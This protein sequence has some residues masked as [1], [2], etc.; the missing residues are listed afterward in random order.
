MVGIVT[1]GS[2]IPI[3]RIRVEEIA[4]VWGDDGERVKKSLGVF[5]K[6]VPGVDEDAATISVEAVRNA[7]R[8]KWIP[9]EEIGAVLVGS[10]SHPYVVKPTA[11]I[12]AEAI[13]ATPKVMAADHE[14]ACKAGT[15]AMQNI[16]GLVKSG[17]IKYGVAIGADTSQG[18]PG[19]PLEYTAS[20]GG[21]A[22]I[23][24]EEEV[25][26]EI[27]HTLSFTTDTPDFWRR[28]KQDYP[29]HGGRF[30]GEPAYFRH[31]LGAAKLMMEEMN[32][33]PED[34]TYAVFHQPNTK[35]PKRVAKKLGFNEEQIKPGLV[36]PWIGN[37][38]SGCMITGLSAIL[39]IAKPGDRILAV[40]FGSGAGSDAFDITVTENIEKINRRA[41]PT[42]R[43]MIERAVY[44]DYAL[45]AKFRKKI[46]LPPGV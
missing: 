37:T 6:S 14:F 35:F 2:Y 18:A 7:L 23:I 38:Y 17:M 8:R 44:I 16:I 45:Y 24:G 9:P 28:E 32:T 13:G 29:Q 5:S 11:T 39:D 22:F 21:T 12:V 19:D 3:Y 31:I 20:A 4:R 27:N 1:Y 41:A 34:Y 42:V 30:T 43:E 46:L 15:A 40:S 26:T 33:K 25:I 10:E 36:V